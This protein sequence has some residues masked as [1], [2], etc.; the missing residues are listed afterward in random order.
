MTSLLRPSVSANAR[1]YF[2]LCSS[3]GIPHLPSVIPTPPLPPLLFVEKAAVAW[4]SWVP[5]L[6]SERLV[7]RIMVPSPKGTRPPSYPSGPA[8]GGGVGAT[9]CRTLV[10]CQC[11]R[12]SLPDGARPGRVLP[13]MG[14][15]GAAFRRQS[16]P[17]SLPA[18]SYATQSSPR[19]H[20]Q[21]RLS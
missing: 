7:P 13:S 12:P 15:S 19:P 9:S 5:D 20:S 16:P 11:R 21:E 10:A 2:L 17:L 8:A 4:S 6:Y 1:H 14:C 18:A 3:L